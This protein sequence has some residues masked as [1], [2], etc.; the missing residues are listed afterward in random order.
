[1]RET[2]G[3]SK[4]YLMDRILGIDIGGTDVKAGVVSAEGRIEYQGTIETR[5]S[6]GPDAL[7]ERVRDWYLENLAGQPPVNVAGLDCAGLVDSGR[8]FLY[9]SPNLE[10]WTDVPIGKIFGEKLG[11][12]V[13]VEN[14]VN[15]AVWG[16]Y[17]LGSG[18]GTSSFVA[19]TLGT[20]VGGGIVLNGSLYRGSSGLAGEIG[21]HVI[22][23]DGPVC[24]C[25]SRGCLEAMIGSPA[26]RSRATRMS[27]G[28]GSLLEGRE[29][30]SVKEIYD[31]AEAGDVAAIRTFEETGNY[32]GI[33][34]ANIVHILNPDRIAI[35]GGVA[36]AGEMILGPARES[37]K[38]HLMGDILRGIEVVP[39]MLGNSASFTGAAMLAAAVAGLTNEER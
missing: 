35:G 24:T 7:A 32:L 13:T 33:G 19:L 25:G 2:P 26:I 28:T 37:M 8:G 5:P 30:L 11:M 38:R 31:A 39:A 36:G 22:L 16:E 18:K 10:G 20:G 9:N 21:H 29:G 14:D 3:A 1:M 4:G 34:L 27:A 6:D 23:A 15:A 17:L 12:S